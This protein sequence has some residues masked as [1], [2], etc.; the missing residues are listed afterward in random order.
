MVS[1]LTLFVELTITLPAGEIT[2]N[3]TEFVPFIAALFF[4]Q[5]NFFTMLCPPQLNVRSIVPDIAA[6]SPNVAFT[7]NARTS[8]PAAEVVAAVFDLTVTPDGRVP[9]V[10]EQAILVVP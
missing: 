3:K 1:R 10:T 7:A 5:E 2:S 8:E 6:L 4:C 9:A